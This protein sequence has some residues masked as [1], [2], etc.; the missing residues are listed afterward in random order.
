V[1]LLCKDYYNATRTRLSFN[2]DA[3]MSLAA[4]TAGH[5][6]CHPILGGLHH[7]YGWI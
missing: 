3:P 7:Q 1:L 4:E 5:I 2:E 6:I